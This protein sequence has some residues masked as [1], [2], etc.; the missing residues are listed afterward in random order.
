M[1]SLFSLNFYLD[2]TVCYV[3]V[4]ILTQINIKSSRHVSK[5]ENRPDSSSFSIFKK[6]SRHTLSASNRDSNVMI[7]KTN[8]CVSIQNMLGPHLKLFAF[9]LV[10]ISLQVFRTWMNSMS[11][12]LLYL[13][14]Y[15]F[16]ATDFKHNFYMVHFKSHSSRT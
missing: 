1:F 14:S 7:W 4:F 2:F 13:S 16:F 15:L 8:V 10:K 3:Y 5:S 12:E 9:H 6:V 11:Q